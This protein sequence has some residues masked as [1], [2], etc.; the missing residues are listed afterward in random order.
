MYRTSPEDGRSCCDCGASEHVHAHW[1]SLINSGC[2]FN[3]LFHTPFRAIHPSACPL[4]Q[5]P[6]A[7]ED[8]D[9]D[10]FDFANMGDDDE[11]D[12]RSPGTD[13]HWSFYP[14]RG[15]GVVTLAVPSW[16]VEA[17]SRRF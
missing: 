4:S 6:P 2:H 16:V 12:V 11:D 8:S 15:A 5:P 17:H 3:A 14:F 7:E 13:W 9:D 10:G 1:D